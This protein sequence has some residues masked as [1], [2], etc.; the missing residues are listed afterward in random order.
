MRAQIHQ[1]G[2]AAHAGHGKIEQYEI[3][4][5]AAFEMRGDF[6]EG[7]GLADFGVAE[8]ARHRLAQRAAEQ[9]M[10]VGNEQMV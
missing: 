2:K 5:G 7:P 3:D 4:V 1:A 10:V 6:L 8:Q 9:R